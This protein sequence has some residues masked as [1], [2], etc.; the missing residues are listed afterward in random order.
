WSS[1]TAHSRAAATHVTNAVARTLTLFTS[2]RAH[3]KKKYLASPFHLGTTAE[4]RALRMISPGQELLVQRPRAGPPDTRKRNPTGVPQAAEGIV[5]EA[6]IPEAL[7]VIRGMPEMSG[8][9]APRPRQAATGAAE[10][11]RR[12]ADPPALPDKAERRP[13]GLTTPREEDLWEQI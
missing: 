4:L 5:P 2:Q 13:A 10:K 3:P 1:C 9:A 7:R 11:P 8:R 12:P 6:P